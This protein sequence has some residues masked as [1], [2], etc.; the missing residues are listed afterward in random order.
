MTYCINNGIIQEYAGLIK[1]L[2]KGKDEIKIVA[3]DKL[4]N[5]QEL[6]LQFIIE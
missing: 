5:T 6:K 4:N 1:N 3:Y 2:P